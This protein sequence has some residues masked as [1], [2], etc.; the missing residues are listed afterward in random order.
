MSIKLTLHRIVRRLASDCRRGLSRFATSV[1]FKGNGVV[2]SSF[3]TNGVPYVFVSRGA[4]MSIGEN[5][6][7][8]NGPHGNPIGCYEKCTFFVGP[9]ACLTIGNNVGMS[10]SSA[11]AITDLCI[12]DYVKIGGGTMIL[13]SDFHS[14]NPEIR[15]SPEDIKNRA[16]APV[17]IEDN[18]FIGARCIILKGVTIG[19]NSIIGAGSVVTRSVPANEIWAGNPARFIK[20]IDR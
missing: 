15:K 10:Q 1:K 17:N 8:N 20:T 13:T 3:R 12:G 9:Q 16:S 11:I 4:K 2:H 6:A 18:V 19:R 14:L 5:F 7:M